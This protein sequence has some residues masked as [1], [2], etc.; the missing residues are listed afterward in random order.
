MTMTSANEECFQQPHWLML[1]RGLHV[2]RWL[3]DGQWVGTGGIEM[4]RAVHLRTGQRYFRFASSAAPAAQVAGGWWIDFENFNTIS[5]FHEKNEMS[6]TEAARLFLALP[7]DWSRVDRLVSAILEVP[8]KAYAGAGKPV[9]PVDHEDSHIGY[10]RSGKG[11]IPE[12]ASSWVPQKHG[13]VTQL[14][15]PGL[16]V[17]R[18]DHSARQLYEI[19]FPHPRIE[20]IVSGRVR[21]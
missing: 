21:I 20:S 14:H 11:Q 8:L 18:E 15:I 17:K 7:Y 5:R 1:A 3:D 4:P 16:Y 13:G 10:G 19:A 9:R 6:L 2:D 12:G